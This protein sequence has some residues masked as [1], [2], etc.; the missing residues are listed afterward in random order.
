L[1]LPLERKKRANLP[2]EGIEPTRSRGT[3]LVATIQW[4]SWN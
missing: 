3:V 1:T 2:A 4:N